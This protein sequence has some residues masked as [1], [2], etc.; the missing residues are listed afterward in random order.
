MVPKCKISGTNN[1][2]CVYHPMV[3]ILFDFSYIAIKKVIGRMNLEISKKWFKQA[4]HDLEIAE[5]N[6]SI[7]GYDVA[8]FLANQAV[9]KLLKSVISF[10]Q[11]K[12]PKIHHLDELANVLSLADSD[13][14]LVLEL[15][16]DYMFTRYPDVSNE[17]PYELYDE[18]TARKKVETAK[19]IFR[20]FEKETNE[21]N[22]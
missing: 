8:S 5:K 6:I 21:F 22:K 3:L 1:S 18:G 11:I 19:Q 12:I 20:I 14:E 9:E 2:K 16:S 13:M 4:K 17:V 15:V 7:E 10:R